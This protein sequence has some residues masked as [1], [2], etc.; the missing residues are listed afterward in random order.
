M[1]ICPDLDITLKQNLRRGQTD[2][3]IKEF[4][5]SSFFTYHSRLKLIL[6]FVKLLALG[7]QSQINI[8]LCY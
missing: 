1:K 5:Q 4:I 7:S 6:N 3:D 2:L 8:F